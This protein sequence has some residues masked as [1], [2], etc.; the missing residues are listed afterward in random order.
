MKEKIFIGI[1]GGISI[2]ATSIPIYN[3]YILHVIRDKEMMDKIDKFDER[4]KKLEK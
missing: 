1:L 2:L 4:L 3:Y